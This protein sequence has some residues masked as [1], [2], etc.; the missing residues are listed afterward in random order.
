MTDA[1]ENVWMQK[2]PD[3]TGFFTAQTVSGQPNLA[4]DFEEILR[5]VDSL[6]RYPGFRYRMPQSFFGS[7][8]P[9]IIRSNYASPPFLR[10]YWVR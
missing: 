4:L 6:G 8:Q 7:Y 9:Q 10:L 2:P 3:R 1:H 5:K